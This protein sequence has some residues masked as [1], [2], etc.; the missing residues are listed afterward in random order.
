MTNRRSEPRFLAEQPVTVGSLDEPSAQIVNGTII[1]FSAS[2]MGVILPFAPTCGSRLR[3][4]WSRG[5]VTAEVR[6]CRRLRPGVYR[7]GL[8]IRELIER[9]G[10]DGQV[11]VA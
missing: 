6:N 5:A 7:I 2:G 3:I 1:D 8:A 4:E 10:I 9:T 11:G